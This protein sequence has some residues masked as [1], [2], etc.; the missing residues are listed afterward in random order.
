MSAHLRA[1]MAVCVQ[2]TTTTR[3]FEVAMV[4]V[5]GGDLLLRVA[6]GFDLFIFVVR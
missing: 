5:F 4:V 6:L 3:G 2:S 1:R